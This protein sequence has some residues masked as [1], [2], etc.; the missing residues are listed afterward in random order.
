MTFSFLLLTSCLDG[1]SNIA[2]SEK[3]I[4]G[5]FEI[6]TIQ[7]KPRAQWATDASGKVFTNNRKVEVGGS[8]FRGVAKIYGYIDGVL[9][10]DTAPCGSTGKYIWTHTFPSDGS[11]AI[12]LS[13]ALNNGTILS[14]QAIETIIVDTM[15]P[16]AP[17]ITTN[18][19]V[20]FVSS[21]PNVLIEGLVSSEVVKLEASNQNAVLSFFDSLDS[22]QYL[23]VLATSETRT[24]SFFAYDLAGN[25]SLPAQ[26]TISFLAN[27]KLAISTFSGANVV[28]SG[29]GNSGIAVMPMVS[30]GSYMTDP[31]SQTGTSGMRKIFTSFL[32][33]IGGL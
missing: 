8:C 31:S 19:G 5:I 28:G 22:F 11:F 4:H 9:V 27:A 15:P 26:I 33:F 2:V 1:S 13:P 17:V 32:D 18:G 10:S 29:V 16:A 12:T 21:V 24:L 6:L 23:I 30:M 3:D 14:Q 20:A 7:A 25:K